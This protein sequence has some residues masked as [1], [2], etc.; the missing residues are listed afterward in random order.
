MIQYFIIPSLINLLLMLNMLP[1][2]KNMFLIFT[3]MLNRKQVMDALM[4]CLWTSIIVENIMET[5]AAE[6]GS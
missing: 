5:H 4:K 6:L 1:T 2:L 3:N